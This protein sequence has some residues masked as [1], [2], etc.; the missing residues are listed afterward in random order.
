MK[1]HV[2]IKVLSIAVFAFFIS[3]L[4][5]THLLADTQGDADINRSVF[6]EV[7]NIVAPKETDGYKITIDGYTLV[8]QNGGMA[9]GQAIIDENPSHTISTWGGE[10]VQSSTDNMNTHFIGHN[11]GVFTPLTDVQKNDVIKVEDKAGTATYK[12][13]KIVVT[14]TKAI[15]TKNSKDYW[16]EIT[17]KEGGERI[18][19]QTCVGATKRLIVFAVIAE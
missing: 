17:G 6:A 19:L 7:A 10:Q 8:Y 13:D 12:I 2:S 16:N 5:S 18:T 9:D 3:I 1:P 14:N 15:D 11:P 4:V